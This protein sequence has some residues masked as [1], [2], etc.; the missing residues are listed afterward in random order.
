MEWQAFGNWNLPNT[1]AGGTTSTATSPFNSPT[2]ATTPHPATR[3]ASPR[4]E[5]T[6]TTGTSSVVPMPDIR[7]W[8]SPDIRYEAMRP[9]VRLALISDKNT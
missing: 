9:N 8:K 2:S 6:A 5:G 7:L 3:A 4:A 1:I